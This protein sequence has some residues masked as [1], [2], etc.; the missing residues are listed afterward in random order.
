MIKGFKFLLRCLLRL[1]YGVKVSGLE[2][3]HSAGDKV[4]IVA[5]HTSLLDG[6]LLY[7]WLPETPTFAINTHVAKKRL[8]RV[9]LKLVDM[10][11]MDPA[12]PLS[13]KSM[14][15][16]LAQNKKTV[17]FPEG[18]ITTTGTLMKIYEGTGMIADKSGAAVL[19]VIIAGAEFSPFSYLR[20]KMGITALFPRISLTILPA[21]RIKIDR[22]IQGR[23]RRSLATQHIKE[24][25]SQLVYGAFNHRTTVFSAVLNNGGYYNKDRLVVEDIN[26]QPVSYRQ[27]VIKSMV[28]GNAMRMSAP[29]DQ[30]L[31]GI[32]LPNVVSTLVVF[33]ATH[34]A[35]RVPA[36]INFSSGE[37]AVTHTCRISKIKTIYTSR[38][39][40]KSAELETL[41]EVLAT[42]F[43][44][45]YLEDL[46]EGISKLDKL[47]G[48]IR[49]FYAKQHYRRI[50]Q[51]VSPDSP[52]VILFT[53]GSDGLPKG[54]ALSHSNV[55]ANYA[56]VSSLFDFNR[57]DVFF[58]CLPLFHS[59]GFT[60][61]FLVPL[62]SGSRI[63]LYP[64]PLHY[65]L[66][67]ELIYGLG[68]TVLFG[69]NT[70]F[71]GYARY[72]HPFD[73]H[74]LRYVV[75][76]AESL[77]DQTQQLW[78]EKF[79][80]R[81]YQGYGMTEMSPVFSANNPMEN[82]L[83]SIGQAMAQISYYLEPVEGIDEGGRLFVRGPNVML[84]YL[85]EETNGTILAP[86]SARGE[87]W[88]DTGDIVRID[89]DGYFYVIG[90]AKR[91][92]KIGG[93][94]ISLAAVEDVAL[95]LWPAFEHACISLPDSKKGERIILATN[96]Q[97]ATKKRFQEQ[98][99]AERCSD[100]YLPYAISPVS[101]VPV[102]ASGK[103][104][105][106]TLKK[107]LSEQPQTTETN[108]DNS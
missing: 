37:Q 41:A 85:L 53:S 48:V 32:M 56:Q 15:K 50:G 96:N 88:H 38:R 42:E 77:S 90:R 39:F 76:G 89:E 80:I 49:S 12:S 5:H 99:R 60:G 97:E 46:A 45:I 62:L 30:D 20:K 4:L 22:K 11:E 100:L 107:M 36:M 64:T 87:G 73:F 40:I 33:L 65:R 13:V 21:T 3:Y 43:E 17:I 6:V 66:I 8:F 70:F 95:R 23:Q 98:I 29:Q 61:G 34:Y 54:V 104:D 1:M 82:R 69:T 18:R 58:S 108:G 67:P 52:A 28:L 25:M 106:V 19:P 57:N 26:R 74:T 44:L 9:F 91:F 2:H 101:D 92:A 102:L 78:M 16:F 31:I 55:L 51:N 93:E 84:G 103:T 63:F 75:A 71:R 27:L 72:A 86:A 7:A 10:F 79:G 59:F 68:V 14:V 47:V 24:I 35:S 81:I 94:M 105:Y 83:G